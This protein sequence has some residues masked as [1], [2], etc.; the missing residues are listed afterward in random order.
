MDVFQGDSVNRIL[1]ASSNV[2]NAQIR[3]IVL[4][5]IAKTMPFSDKFKNILHG[6]ASARHAWLA[7][8]DIRIDSNAIVQGWSPFTQL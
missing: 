7:K 5:N 3:I 1:N 4:D 2:L 6:N 8:M